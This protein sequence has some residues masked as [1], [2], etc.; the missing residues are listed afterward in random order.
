[1]FHLCLNKL[2]FTGLL[3]LLLLLFLNK[4][5]CFLLETLG[6]GYDLMFGDGSCLLLPPS[7]SLY[8][9]Y[10]G[11][12]I[13]ME[14]TLWWVSGKFNSDYYLNRDPKVVVYNV[15]CYSYALDDSC[16]MVGI[17]FSTNLEG[18]WNSYMRLQLQHCASFTAFR[19]INMN[20][21]TSQSSAVWMD[22]FNVI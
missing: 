21:K 5:Y 20:L 12:F 10:R 6:L 15:W 16:Y 13:I 9:C 17:C 14:T 11:L 22:G 1:M 8:R 7:L 19:R 4:C 18:S 3:L 2:I